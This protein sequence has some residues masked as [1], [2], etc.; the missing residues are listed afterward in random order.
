[1]EMGQ[2]LQPALPNLH[3]YRNLKNAQTWN[4]R[5]QVANILYM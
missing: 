2:N 3:S 5:M 4:K 1:M